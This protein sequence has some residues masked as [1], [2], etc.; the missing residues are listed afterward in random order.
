M[1]MAS[2]FRGYALGI[3]MGRLGFLN[4]FPPSHVDLV[5]ELTRLFMHVPVSDDRLMLHTTLNSNEFSVT[6]LNEISIAHSESDTILE[7]DLHIDHKFGGSH[8]ANSAIV[9]TPTGSTAYALSAGGAILHPSMDAIQIV[10]VAPLYMASRPVV[11]PGKSTI[12][13]TVKR[14]KTLPIVIRSDGQK[15]IVD[16]SE[17]GNSVVTVT[18][19]NR[20]SSM[21]HTLDWNFFEVLSSKMGW[22]R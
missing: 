7:F 13:I 4:D 5:A 6:S 17:S 15:V 21:L 22:V 1:K 14:R 10:P 16:T 20:V 9:S 12:S 3:N 2:S 11:V 19:A 8:R 18:R